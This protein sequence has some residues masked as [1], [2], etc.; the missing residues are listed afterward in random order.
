MI[1]AIIL[2]SFIVLKENGEK[3]GK[4]DKRDS[5]WHG[6][7][8]KHEGMD[9]LVVSRF[10][11]MLQISIHTI[12]RLSLIKLSQLYERSNASVTIY[13][14]ILFTRQLFEIITISYF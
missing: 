3:E 11:A 8:Y 10:S 2:L 1:F 14:T 7:I 5:L 12:T 9:I 4:K 13:D 6:L